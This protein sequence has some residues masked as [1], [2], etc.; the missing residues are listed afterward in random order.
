MQVTGRDGG[1]AITQS[2][3]HVYISVSK[4]LDLGLLWLGLMT[5]ELWL[6]I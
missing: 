1:L 3:I 5:Q 2:K 6:L 4:P